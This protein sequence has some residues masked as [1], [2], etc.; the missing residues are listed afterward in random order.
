MWLET[1][2]LLTPYSIQLVPALFF[3][4]VDP[5]LQVV[6]VAVVVVVVSLYVVC[7]TFQALSVFAEL[8]SSSSSSFSCILPSYSCHYAIVQYTGLSERSA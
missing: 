8:S 2:L 5:R 6:V 1:T 3:S 7:S 4:L